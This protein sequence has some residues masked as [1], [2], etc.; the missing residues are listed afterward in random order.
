MTFGQKKLV[1]KVIQNCHSYN[2]MNKHT[3]MNLINSTCEQTLIKYIN[4]TLRTHN[5]IIELTKANLK[6]SVYPIQWFH[7]IYQ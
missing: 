6:F 3:V 5:K 7:S 2:E 4:E 1:K